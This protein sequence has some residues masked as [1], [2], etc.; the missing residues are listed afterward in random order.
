MLEAAL[1]DLQFEC[2]GAK[3]AFDLA[4]LD[5]RLVVRLDRRAEIDIDRVDLGEHLLRLRLLRGDR[6]GVGSRSGNCGKCGRNC[7]KERL[8]LSFPADSHCWAAGGKTGAPGGPVRHKSGTLTM[9]SDV[10]KPLFGSI[11]RK[12]V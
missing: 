11:C 3:V 7:N 8:R 5:R 2:V 12:P 6:T 1:R 10:C 4:Q 9:T